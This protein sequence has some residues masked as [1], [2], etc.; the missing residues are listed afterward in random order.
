MHQLPA[1]FIN[2][3]KTVLTEDSELQEFV[4]VLSSGSPTSIRWNK[5]KI[6]SDSDNAKKVK[7]TERAYYLDKRPLF[8]ADPLLHAGAYYVQ[9]A[10]SMFVEQALRQTVNTDDSLTVLDLCAAPGGK[11]TLI[12]DLINEDS[13]LVSNEVIRS[14][15]EILSENIQKWGRHNAIVT[16][17]DPSTFGKLLPD[18]FDVIVVD[19][20]CS[21]E[22]MFRKMNE[23]IGEWSLQNVQHC[24]LR[25]QRILHD[26][27]NALRPGGILIYSTCTY[28]KIENEDNLLKFRKECDFESLKLN[29]EN[30]WNI[31]ETS[32]ENLFGYRFYPHKTE[33][34][35]F[36]ISVLQKAGEGERKIPN[37]KKTVFNKVKDTSILENWLLKSEDVKFVE[38]NNLI[39]AFPDAVRDEFIAVNSFLNI[40]YSGCRIAEIGRKGLIPLHSFA[41]WHRLNKDFFISN[42]I[43]LEDAH[44]YL[45]TEQPGTEAV[46]E[47]DGIQLLTYKGLGLGWIKKINNRINNYYPKE[48]KIRMSGEKLNSSI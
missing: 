40:V 15:S 48:W 42:E 24:A 5:F 2:Q 6:A 36:F 12:A 44:K 33:G 23:S 9:E 4:D 7:W 45:K 27:W 29:I 43:G 38:Q 19:A 20:P 37:V 35:G 46:S 21:G 39:C 8:T 16:Q 1:D 11:S 10:S 41:L 28:N 13:L 14:R 25:Q 34:E 26:V 22:G 47:K 3:M 18:F 32:T 30:E 31:T 17:N